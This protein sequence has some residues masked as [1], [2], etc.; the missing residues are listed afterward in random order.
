M[1]PS[2][3][4]KLIGS[5]SSSE[6][7]YFKLQTKRQGGSKEYLLL[8]QLIDSMKNPDIRQLKQEFKKRSP[9]GSWENTC[10]Y[11]GSSLVDCLVRAK[12]EKDIFFN[13]L[14]QLQEVRILRERSLEEEAFRQASKVGHLAAKYQLHWIEYYCYRDEL[15]HYSENNFAG[16]TDQ[17]LVTLQMKGKNILK[18]LS[19]IHDH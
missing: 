17:G 8:F 6:K 16:I 18:S 12:K 19:H 7:R 3:L 14:H 4:V 15:Q 1:S 13:L 5:L 10:I 11:L 2:A 9:K